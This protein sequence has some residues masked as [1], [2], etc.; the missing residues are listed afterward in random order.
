MV[1]SKLVELHV[2]QHLELLLLIKT[3]QFAMQ[4]RAFSKYMPHILH[5]ACLLHADMPYAISVA[6]I[7]KTLLIAL[8][9]AEA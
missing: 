2:G 7:W 1:V 5:I 6:R 4:L 8:Q 3:Q 9:S